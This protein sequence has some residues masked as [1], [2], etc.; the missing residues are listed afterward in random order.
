MEVDSLP[1]KSRK[2]FENDTFAAWAEAE[3][4]E[5][6]ILAESLRN[7]LCQ[8][9]QAVCYIILRRSDPPL[10]EEA[11]DR[12]MISLDSYDASRALFSTWAHAIL[13]R[14]MY[15]Q[16]REERERKEQPIERAAKKAAPEGYAAVELVETVRS[17]L[18]QESFLLFEKIV[19][20]G[21]TQGEAAEE[22]G[23]SR[24]AVVRKWPRIVR[25]LRNALSEHFPSRG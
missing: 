11:A 19:L 9:A 18:S 6:E 7:L 12:V 25:I 4:R 21:S 1:V 5:K 13:M 2:H 17:I 15:S 23:L 3:G 8:H 24:A 22:L 16:R 10:V 14:V 20:L